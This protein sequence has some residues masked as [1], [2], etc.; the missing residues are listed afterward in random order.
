MK[1]NIG[2]ILFLK[3][4]KHIFLFALNKSKGINITPF[5]TALKYE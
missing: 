4:K 5:F 3:W 1:A 2:Y